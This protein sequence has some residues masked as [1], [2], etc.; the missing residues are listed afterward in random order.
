M[1]AGIFGNSW[2]TILIAFVVVLVLR[3]AFEFVRRNH[4]AGR[5]EE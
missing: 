3:A 5:S 2:L 1:A 4:G